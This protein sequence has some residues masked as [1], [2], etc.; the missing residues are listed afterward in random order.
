MPVF[1]FEGRDIQA[2]DGE[3]V[4]S[5]LL[6]HDV[7]IQHGCQAGACQSCL[8]RSS[9]AVPPS[10][11]TGLDETLLERGAFLS[12]Q[13]KAET[14]SSVEGLGSEVF[15]RFTATML[16]K[17]HLAEDVLLLRLEAEGWSAAPG[18]F[19][20]LIDVSGVSR[21]YSLATPAS[22]PVSEIQ[23]HVRLIP[24]GRMSEI[25][26]NSSVG[27]QF[28]V[29]GPFGKCSYRSAD[30]FEPMLLIGSGTGLAPLYAIVTDALHRGHLGPIFL[31]HGGRSSA[32]L[33]FRGE[34]ANLAAR[35]PQLTV[36]LCADAEVC[37][38]DRKGSPLVHALSEH[39]Q[40]DG[41]KVYLC[42]HPE[43]V[44]SAQRKCFL[45][46]ANLKDIAADPFVAA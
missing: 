15:P 2:E 5:A 36:T 13:A 20:R 9:D 11:Q 21:P 46:G 43:L 33:Y 22:R 30:H 37:G 39:P 35:N 41:F 4:L 14:V 6:R 34:L 38:N 16:E 1:Q 23:L 25:V 10:A 45:A 24:G 42:G 27:G 8:L 26:L 29:E 19:I 12:C 28:Q 7:D 40:L 44:K 17:R 32:S 3:T 18:R 31:Y